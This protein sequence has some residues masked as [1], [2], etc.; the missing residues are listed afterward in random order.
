MGGIRRKRTYDKEFRL[1]A[2]RLVLEE[3]HSANAVMMKFNIN[4][5][6]LVT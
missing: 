3:G 2:V 5:S 6:N 4:G 1:E